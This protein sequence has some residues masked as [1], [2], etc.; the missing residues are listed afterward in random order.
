[1]MIDWSTI[2]ASVITALAT[3]SSV[4]FGHKVFKN[5]SKASCDSTCR[6]P[7]I[8]DTLQSRNVYKA[9]EFI[10]T[11]LC[12]DRAYVIEFHNGNSYLSG[13]GQQ[14]FSCTHEIVTEGTSREC[15]DMQEY[16]VSN[17]HSYISHLIDDGK[18]FSFNCE[19]LNDHAFSSLL[20]SKGVKSI[21]NVP[22]KTL[23][24]NIIGILGVD[25]V[26]ANIELKKIREKFGENDF[27]LHLLKFVKSQARA[28]GGYLI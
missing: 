21:L 4:I 1:M 25:Y 13:R 5:R 11:E 27:E 28:I 15:I 3:I 9:L 7:V 14:K 10:L 8:K 18:F 19:E 12:A 6:D 16:K 23:N 26:K 20:H 22:I 24:G 2:I 17:Y